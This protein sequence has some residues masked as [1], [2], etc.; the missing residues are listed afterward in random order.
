MTPTDA[1]TLDHTIVWTT[2]RARGAQFLAHVLDLAA[3]S[4]EVSLALSPQAK[5]Q[6]MRLSA[7][8]PFTSQAYETRT[9]R[10]C[11]AMTFEQIAAG[12]LRGRKYSLVICSF[13]MHL[14]DL[15]RLP[16]LCW[17]LAQVADQLM[18]LTPHKR[19]AIQSVWNWMLTHERMQER[20]RARLYVTQR[21]VQPAAKGLS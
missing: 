19:P 8:D 4:G 7:I 2:D 9:G 10:P 21:A 16:T 18:I 1:P 14:V 13:A 6:A 20:V 15:S 11:E 5:T 12:G 3:G 17:E